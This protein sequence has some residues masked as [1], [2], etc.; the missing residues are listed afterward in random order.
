MLDRHHACPTDGRGASGFTLI[1]SIVALAALG[2]IM[3]ASFGLFTLMGRVAGQNEQV[4]R[5]QAGARVAIEDLERFLRSAGAEVDIARGQRNFVF[6]G[7]YQVAFNANITPN[8]DPTGTLTPA[9]LNPAAPNSGVPSDGSAFYVP[10]ASFTTGAET[11]VF[12]LDSNQNG[13]VDAG[14]KADDPE[15]RSENPNDYVLYRNVY[16]A[17]NGANTVE[18]SPVAVVRGPEPSGAGDFVPPLFS[19]WIDADDDRTTPPVLMGDANGDGEVDAGEA[20]GLAPLSARDLARIER[21]VVTVT[22]ETASPNHDVQDFGGYERITMQTEVKIR[23]VPRSSG[24][25]FGTVFRDVDGDGVRGP[26]ESAISGV[27]IRASS[28]Q[29]TRTNAS[30]D[31][32]LVVS[33]G[34]ITVTET[35]PTGYTSSTDN[36]HVVDAYAGSYTRLDFGDVPA[37]GIGT[38][39]GR[40]YHDVNENGIDEGERGI[41]NVKIFSDTGEYTF[42]NG[43]GSYTLDVQVGIRSIGQVDS[44]GYVSTT[45]NARE[46]EVA[47]GGLV[48]DVDFGD[49]LMGESGTIEGYVFND[50]DRD[51]VQGRGE[52][53]IPG[54][55]IVVAGNS[56]ESDTQGFYSITVPIGTYVVYENDPPG[57][58]S[59]TPNAIYDVE[60][61][62]DR[63][64]TVNFGDIIREDLDF[65]VIELADTEKALSI[66]AGDLREDNRGDPD[67]VLGTRFAGGSNNLLAWHNQRR[68]SST[69]NNAIFDTAPS[70]TRA[71]PADVTSLV[72]ADLDGDRDLDVIT[73]LA[74]STAPDLNVWITDGGL[75][76]NFASVSNTSMNGQ[77]IWDLQHADVDGD[78]V[79]DLVVAV[80]EV[81][82][83]TG[84]VEIWK[85]Y[86]DGT[87]TTSESA[88]IRHQVN[89]YS[90]LGVVTAAQVADLDGDGRRDLVIGSVDGPGRSS[91]HV[92]LQSR[93][94]LLVDWLPLQTFDV[95]GEITRIRLE[96]LV[97]DD[98]GDVD[99]VVASATSDITGHIE[100]WH[101]GPAGYFGLIGE[102]GRSADDLM[103]TGG[104][105][106]SLIV[107]RLDND[108]FPDTVIGVRRNNGFEGTVE[109]ALGF[110]HLLSEPI[111]ITEWSIGAVLTMT[112]SDF[113]LDGVSDL[114]VGTQN[115][116]TAGK[117]FVFF[118]R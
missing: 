4:A 15:E 104:A 68:N 92:Y 117:I 47:D 1:E 98:Q 65:E 60:V 113:N 16:G 29:E 44:T 27:T 13:A 106:L 63:V 96:D 46:V 25:I 84:H 97:E 90:T 108:V 100:I 88:A 51:G 94:G 64:T 79:N 52:N 35:D 6:A 77:V 7:P 70:M 50:L 114:A 14:D 8:A 61:L 31:Y 72:S 69:P 112:E 111:P 39:S 86:R 33:P 67:L 87:F 78:G 93:L 80:E 101:Q 62:A 11:I 91:V 85:G 58:T 89:G 23:Q 83:T 81:G 42:T 3:A 37:A 40:V 38:V 21:V 49:A 45:P 75:L 74:T 76:P 82:S 28:G 12:T 9:A 17:D 103:P 26:T 71:N 73:G 22:S 102:S 54:A 19:Y 24:V 95:M 116:S 107:T 109:Y 36:T 48:T 118:R 34:T 57:Y 53:G 66:T 18:M 41:A 5:S 115:S 110:G 10:A 32:V 99:I 2:L 43:L 20:A 30:G 55:E 56:T 59:T 105:P